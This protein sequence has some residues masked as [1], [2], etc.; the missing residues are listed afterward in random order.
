MSTEKRPNRSRESG[1]TLVLVALLLVGFVAM[2]GLVLDGG[3]IYFQRRRMQNAAD[4]GAIA[5]AVILAK[6]GTGEQARTKALEYA[7]TQNL[8][9]S[10]QVTISANS[11]T[12]VAHETA[13]T[14]FARILGINNI[15]VNATA[16]AAWAPLGAIYGC[17]PIAVRD[18][19]YEID[20]GQEYTI[21]DDTKDYD[22]LSG[23]ISGGYRGW[24]NMSCVYPASCGAGGASQLKDWM[25]NGYQGI[26]RIDSW[27][28]G[29]PGVKSSVIN[30]AQVGQVLRVV[31][32][33]EIQTKYPGKDYYHAIKFAAF[34]VTKVYGS[35][36]PKGIK[37]TWQYYFF[38]GE[39]GDP[40][41]SEDGGIR[42][43][44]MVR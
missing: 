19:D 39:P 27:I 41:G 32:Y 7:V 35:G 11:V 1:Q 26:L 8:A 6:N 21:W 3:N 4:A 30:Q 14:T 5:G 36:N 23:N 10:A 25:R 33:D 22:P 38:P 20:P 28:R 9:E 31:I 24:L 16:E 43:V 12:V 34:Q 2:L 13:N 40:G 37:G 29:D 17:A 42:T 18:F 44:T 15:D